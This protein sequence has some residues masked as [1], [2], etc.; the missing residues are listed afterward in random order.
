MREQYDAP[1]SVRQMHNVGVNVVELI[2]T[3][4]TMPV[5]IL[6]RPQYGTRYF[7][8][9]VAFFSAMLMILI[10]VIS[11]LATG[12]I[13]LNPFAGPPPAPVGLFGFSSLTTLF[14]F[15]MLLHAVRLWRRT[16]YM[17]LELNSQFEGP[18]LPFFRF[19]PGSRSFW[20]TRIVLEPIFV[21]IAASVLEILFILQ[22]GLTTYLHIAAF[23][24]MV[25]NFIGWFRAWEYIR[26]MMDM[27]F[28]GPIIAKLAQNEATEDDLAPIHLASFPK[29]LA[30]EIREAAVDHIARAYSPNSPISNH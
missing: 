10:P 19:I 12:L 21:F 1:M 17:E 29:N 27:R 23:M 3:V 13:H 7:P 14:F 26:T 2:C 25:K 20:F 5:E 15:L 8:L 4:V 16:I 6:L 30:P 11:S 22:S 24:L 9:P 18:P 28:A